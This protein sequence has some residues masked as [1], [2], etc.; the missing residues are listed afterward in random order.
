MVEPYQCPKVWLQETWPQVWRWNERGRRIEPN[1]LHSLALYGAQ[2]RPGLAIYGVMLGKQT[3]VATP[4]NVPHNTPDVP[5]S[6][7][8]YYSSRV[9]REREP[10]LPQTN[11]CPHPNT[12]QKW[13]AGASGADG[14]GSGPSAVEFGVRV[15]KVLLFVG[16]IIGAPWIGYIGA[17]R[18]VISWKKAAAALASPAWANIATIAIDA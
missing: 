11:R 1:S 4:T 5:R 13:A 8:T 15:L 3:I 18:L 12:R 6:E 10:L 16:V 17:A 2:N 7:S 9:S 14:R